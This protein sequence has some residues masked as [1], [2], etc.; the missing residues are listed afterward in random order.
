M[1]IIR[2]PK[3]ATMAR[4][5]MSKS[6]NGWIRGVFVSQGPMSGFAED[7]EYETL[8]KAEKAAAALAQQRNAAYLI[9]EDCT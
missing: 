4:M 2:L 3:N 6:S 1:E 7:A 9:I 5:T 8:E